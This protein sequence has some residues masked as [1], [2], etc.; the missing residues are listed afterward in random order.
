MH[1]CFNCAS[2]TSHFPGVQQLLHPSSLCPALGVSTGFRQRLA[3][4]SALSDLLQNSGFALPTPA[5]S[6]WPKA[7]E[8]P[9][10]PSPRI[11]LPFKSPPQLEQREIVILLIWSAPAGGGSPVGHWATVQMVPLLSD[12][13]SVGLGFFHRRQWGD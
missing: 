12:L 5:T 3:R 2:V 6:Q 10:T 13:L 9:Q 7:K 11:W 8:T 4:I 1:C